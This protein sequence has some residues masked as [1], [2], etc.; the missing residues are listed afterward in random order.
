[1]AVAAAFA[2]CGVAPA[3]AQ[4]PRPRPATPSEARP[5][6][7]PADTVPSLRL[8]VSADTTV[9]PAD[10]RWPIGVRASRP[11][12]VV[13]TVSSVD[14]PA[15]VLWR[16]DTLAAGSPGVLAWD[17]HSMGGEGLPTGR[18]LLGVSG[19]DASGAAAQAQ[20]TLYVTRLAADT[21]PL[22]R[23]LGP[24]ELEPDTVEVRQTSPWAIFIGAGA[25]LLPSLIGRRE[26]NDGRSGD[27]K[28][29]IVVGSV[30]VAGF[31]AFLAGHRQAFS[32][33]N[34]AHNA[35]VRRERG[36]QVA[37]IVEANRRARALAAYR[38]VVEGSGP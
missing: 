29:W 1:V 14:Q 30:T 16:S 13:A 24:R 38:I 10:E 17:L 18:Y 35:Q 37:T 34:A 36:E 20:R 23:P 3:R 26:L 33:E 11:M 28:T 12:A 8:T 9:F 2:V 7:A 15:V 22:P 25:G 5:T 6:P 31:V 4:S 27:P 21:Q 19:R 32:P